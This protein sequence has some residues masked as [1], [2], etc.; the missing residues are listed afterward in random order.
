MSSSHDGSP[1]LYW[2]LKAL[3]VLTAVTLGLPLLFGGIYLITLGGSWYYA[4]A[5][6]AYTYAAVELFRG[7]MRGVWVLV[8][9]LVITALWA[10][11]ESRG[12]NFWAFEARVVAPMFLAGLALLLTRRIPRSNGA[13]AD[14]RPYALAGGALLVGFVGFLVAMFFPHGI[15]QNTLP[16]TKGAVRAA[17]TATDGQ[18]LSYARTG[19]A[20]RFAPFDQIN[21][22]NVQALEQVWVAHSGDIADGG[23]SG[24]ED[25]NTPLYADGIVYQ[26]S[27]MNIVTALD[28]SS[29]KVLW[30]FDPKSKFAFWKRCRTLGYYDPALPAAV[31]GQPVA[32]AATPASP[33]PATTATSASVATTSPALCATRIFVANIDAKLYALDAKTGAVCADFGVNGMIDLNAGMGDVQPGFYVPTTSPIVAGTRILIRGWIGDNYSWRALRRGARV[34]CH[35]RPAG[36]GLGFG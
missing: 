36:L 33:P 15:V 1:P 16:I 30:R 8:A 12:W 17:T 19:E 28:G 23:A 14:A 32:A 26:C 6:A 27:P 20:T 10:L 34:R 35:H 9:A 29:G 13:P 31:G 18:W 7:R 24:K 5:G 4:L 11:V 21:P 2:G 3:A 25:Q 22:D